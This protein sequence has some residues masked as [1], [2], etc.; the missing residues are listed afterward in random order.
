MNKGKALNQEKK[1]YKWIYLFLLPASIIF[2][3]FYFIPVIKMFSTSF[4]DWDG[5]N[6]PVFNGIR[7]YTKL[8]LN[9]TFQISV[10]NL[11]LWALI[12][13]FLHVGFGVLIAFILYQ[14]P[15]GWKLT[16]TVFMI[17]NVIST[18]AW[19]LIYKFIFNNQI[20]ILNNL[21]RIMYPEF[22]I[23]WFFKSP[24][25]FIAITLTWL[26]YAVVVTLIVLG[27]LM[28]IPSDLNEA[29]KID[30][31]SHWQLIKKVQLPLCRNSIGVSIICTISSRITMYETI[32]LTTSGGPGDDTMNLPL[33]LVSSIL[34]MNYGYANAVGSIMFLIGLI[35][36]LIINKV[37]KMDDP[38]Y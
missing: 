6:I 32:K 11:L 1:Y 17:P 23:L 12:G 24:Y 8:F 34:D 27:D 29:A 36:M 14:N 19:A 21:I 20:G 28:A 5:F 38:V 2:M 22:E 25:A 4:T 31:A 3:L 37:L 26:F 18:A 15:I 7:N 30:G 16:R 33:I 13:I 35:V 9:S 10:R